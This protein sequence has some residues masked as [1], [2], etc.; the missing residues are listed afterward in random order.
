L[1]VGL[2]DFLFA[3]VLLIILMSFYGVAPTCKFFLIPLFVALAL[4]TSLGVGLWFSALNARFRDVQLAIPSLVQIWLFA[5]PIVYSSSSV[6]QSWHPIYAINPMVSVIDG[7]R[8]SLFG[9]PDLE[10][11]VL[12]VSSL[13]AIIGL[14]SGWMFFNHMQ[15]TFADVL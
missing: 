7:F 13:T 5:S 4:V 15:D 9:E 10:L 2:L 14:V 6:P 1:A 11:V 8:W 12:T 3:F